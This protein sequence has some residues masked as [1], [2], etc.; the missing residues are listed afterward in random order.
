MHAP[1]SALRRELIPLEKRHPLAELTEALRAFDAGG[2][3][4][5]TFEYT[6]IEGVNDDFALAGYGN[7]EMFDEEA[8]RDFVASVI[9]EEL[10]GTLGERITRNVRRLVRRE[11][12]RAMTLKDFE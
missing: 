2:G 6:M 5:I 1:D 10:Q 4:R 7:D 3:K 8:L 9:R 12:Q 11:V